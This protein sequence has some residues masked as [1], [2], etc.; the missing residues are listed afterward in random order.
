[1]TSEILKYASKILREEYPTP[2]VHHTVDVYKGL[3]S[4]ERQILVQTQSIYPPRLMQTN[5]R[6]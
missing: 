5:P 4:M 1:M 2:R 6:P 3:N